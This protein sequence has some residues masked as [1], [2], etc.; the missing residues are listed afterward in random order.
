MDLILSL[1]GLVFKRLSTILK[2]GRTPNLSKPCPE[3]LDALHRVLLALENSHHPNYW[4]YSTMLTALFDQVFLVTISPTS[5]VWEILGAVALFSVCSK[6][7]SI[8]IQTS[9][10]SRQLPQLTGLPIAT[11]S[12]ILEENWNFFSPHYIGMHARHEAFL[13]NETRSGKLYDAYLNSVVRAMKSRITEVK[14]LK[15]VPA[16]NRLG[17]IFLSFFGH[18]WDIR[19]DKDLQKGSAM[20]EVIDLLLHNKPTL[21]KSLL[22]DSDIPDDVFDATRYYGPSV[23]ALQW[24]LKQLYILKAVPNPNHSVVIMIQYLRAIIDKCKEDAIIFTFEM[25]RFG[26]QNVRLTLPPSFDVGVI[27]ATAIADGECVDTSAS[28]RTFYSCI[29][30]LF[31]DGI[32][33]EC[34]GSILVYH[35]YTL[36]LGYSS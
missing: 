3:L 35:L 6:D 23:T 24:L 17:A 7:N 11:I 18:G 29:S 26:W 15:S 1:V 30:S 9:Y 21:P 27:D 33:A 19:I 5:P 34:H 22:S 28:V 32:S 20:S 2:R 13:R 36:S 12:R 16:L 14:N 8:E 25:E 31:S 10:S 4:E